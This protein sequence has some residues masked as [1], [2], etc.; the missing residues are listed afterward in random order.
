M[1]QIKIHPPKQLPEQA[2][3]QQQ[4][5]DWVNELEIYLGQDDNMARFMSDGLYNEWLSQEQ[6]PNR[7]QALLDGDPD[8][9][10]ENAQNRAAKQRE[11]LAKRRRE[12]RTFIGQV[13]KSASKNMYA[14]IVRHATSL[15]WIYNKIREDYDIQTKGIHYLNI[16]DVTYDPETKT[17]AGFYHEYRTVILNNIGRRGETIHW[18]PALPAGNQ[19]LAADEV[20]GPLF[21]DVILMNVLQLIDPRLPKFVRKYY[22]LKLGDRRLMD[23]KTDI[24]NNIKEFQSEMEAAEQLAAIRLSGTP[25]ATTDASLAAI[26]SSRPTRGRGR[27]RGIPQ[28]Q[29]VRNRTFCKSCYE[30]DKGR[31]IYL[32]HVTD[33]H[34][35]PTKLKLNTIV[36]QLLPPEVT[37]YEQEQDDQTSET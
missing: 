23:I 17:P 3:S 33:A 4:F 16:V 7:L 26:A 24:F 9:P 19:Q 18:Y 15:N 32:S 20:I 36:D 29:P 5:E 27:G 10:E 22:Q 35:C 1:P 8:Q 11:L 12:L 13:A 25:T 21:E 28:P 34:N 2:I 37:E 30:N 31:S 14:G 6:E